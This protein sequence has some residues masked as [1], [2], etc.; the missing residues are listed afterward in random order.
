MPESL[1]PYVRCRC[2][3]VAL[4]HGEE[5]LAGETE[6]HNGAVQ[7]PD[8]GAC[9]LNVG[10]P[11]A[12]QRCPCLAFAEPLPDPL[13][14]CVC[15]HSRERHDG[16]CEDEPD[17]IYAGCWGPAWGDGCDA[18]CHEFEPPADRPPHASARR[19]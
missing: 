6:L 9:L 13:S 14:V 19:R 4:T 1:K 12:A 11:G 7:Q 18:M 10:E 8:S 3:H 17:P 2:G 5:A 15:G 16:F